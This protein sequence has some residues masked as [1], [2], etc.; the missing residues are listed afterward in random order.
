MGSP[1]SAI[2]SNLVM[3]DVEQRALSSSPIQP[4]FWKRYVDDAI[5]ALS[6][7][8]GERLLSYLNPVEQSIQFTFEREN[9]RCLPFFDLRWLYILFYEG[10][11]ITSA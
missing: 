9:E 8:E 1:V 3:E 6:V 5:S 11:N 10:L 4:L 2:I 7:N